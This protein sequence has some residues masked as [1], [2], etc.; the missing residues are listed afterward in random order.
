MVDNQA[1]KTETEKAEP[2]NSG[3]FWGKIRKYAGRI[4]IGFALFVIALIA[5]AFFATRGVSNAADDFIAQLQA[6]ECAAIF[7]DTSTTFRAQT[8]EAQWLSVCE[9]IG[10]I[11]QGEPEQTN[12]EIQANSGG[13]SIGQATYMIAGTDGN[14]Y[15]VILQVID[16][17]GWKL[18]ALDSTGSQFTDN[19][20]AADQQ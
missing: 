14:D 11:L 18:D 9:T 10:P 1:P 16:E 2:E 5:L 20:G 15:R 13:P 4:L 12:V 6:G 19:E 17:D 8:N 3:G 7:E